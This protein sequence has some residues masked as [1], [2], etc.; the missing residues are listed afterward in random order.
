MKNAGTEKTICTKYAYYHLM[1]GW[2]PA[3][4]CANTSRAGAFDQLEQNAINAKIPVYERYSIDNL[5]GMFCG[6]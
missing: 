5:L 2:K 1:R 6:T 4:V 3:L